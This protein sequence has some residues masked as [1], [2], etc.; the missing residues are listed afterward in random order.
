MVAAFARCAS[1]GAPGSRGKVARYGGQSA[2]A[3]ET[4]QA[5]PGVAGRVRKDFA[6]RTILLHEEADVRHIRE[7][8]HA[9]RARAA[10][11][12]DQSG[13]RPAGASHPY[14][15]RTLLRPTLRRTER[16]DWGL[17]RCEHAL[18]R[19]RRHPARRAPT[20]RNSCGAPP[21]PVRLKPD[22]TYTWRRPLE[23][24]HDWI[25]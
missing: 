23:H 21:V 24:G 3:H 11:R 15:S 20:R 22:T 1:Y 7:C 8:G 5:L 9:S 17:P 19:T 2:R 4:P 18:E 12:L 14:R 25:V 6:R 10:W 16:M 13:A